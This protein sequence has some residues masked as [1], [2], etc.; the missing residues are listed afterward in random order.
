MVKPLLT[1][2]DAELRRGLDVASK[3]RVSREYRDRLES[4]RRRFGHTVTI[5]PDGL[6]RIC[7][8]NCFA[9]ALGVWKT[10]AYIE[11]VEREGTSPVLDSKAVQQK[12]DAGELSDVAPSAVV[13]GD[14]A[15]YFHEGRLTHAAV[16]TGAASDLVLQSVIRRAQ[17]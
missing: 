11:R 17:N 16:I 10:D 9:F 12:I 13:P 15:L 14:L 3:L 7:R 5:L 8:F 2:G 1:S 6:E 4:L